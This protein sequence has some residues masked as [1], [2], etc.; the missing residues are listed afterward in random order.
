MRPLLLLAMGTWTAAMVLLDPTAGL[1]AG[2][3]SAGLTL[4]PPRRRWWS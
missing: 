2:L 3:F 1:A 4:M